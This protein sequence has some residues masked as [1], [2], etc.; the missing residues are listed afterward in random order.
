LTKRFER[1]DAYS[2]ASTALRTNPTIYDASAMV[3]FSTVAMVLP[4][5]FS[6][7]QASDVRSYSIK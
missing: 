4:S 2:P 3:T 6:V 1:V 5:G 7:P